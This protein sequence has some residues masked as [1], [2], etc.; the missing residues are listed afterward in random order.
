MERSEIVQPAT[1][2]WRL[3]LGLGLGAIGILNTVL[4]F[5]IASNMMPVLLALSALMAL[6]GLVQ[7]SLWSK[8]RS[9][10]L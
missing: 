10:W 1:A 2:T 8:H 3:W 7:F 4:S 6:A 9:S 5:S